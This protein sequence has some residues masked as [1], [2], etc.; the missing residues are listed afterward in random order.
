ML[1]ATELELAFTQHDGVSSTRQLCELCRRTGHLHIKGC[2]QN[3][4]VL[5]SLIQKSFV[6]RIQISKCSEWD[7]PEEHVCSLS[8]DEL[9]SGTDQGAV[10]ASASPRSVSNHWAPSSIRNALF[11]L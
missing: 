11:R 7:I 10:L 1:N 6:S 4:K 9:L 2:L 8:Q 5:P 3:V